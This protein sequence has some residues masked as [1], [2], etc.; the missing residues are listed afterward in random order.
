VADKKITFATFRKYCSDS[1]EYRDDRGRYCRYC[2]VAS[3]TNEKN[4]CSEKE[5][6]V[7]KRLRNV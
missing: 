7:W 1:M 5:C 3:E 4:T 2:Y 6:P